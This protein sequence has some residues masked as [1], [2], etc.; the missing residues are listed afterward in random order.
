MRP[1]V[2]YLHDKFEYF[3]NLCYQGKLPHPEIKLNRRASSMG[4]TRATYNR[5]TRE[6]KVWIEISVKF[7]LPETEVVDTLLHEMIHYYIM[8]FDLKDS[9]QHG[10]LF[11]SEMRRLYADYG[12]KVS[13]KF[14][15]TNL[16]QEQLSPERRYF[17]LSKDLCGT[18]YITVVATSRIFDIWN[19]LDNYNLISTEWYVGIH[20]E[21]MKYPRS[22]GVKFYR[23][24]DEIVK[25]ILGSSR[26]LI[27]EG[28]I[29][30][31]A[32]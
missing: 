7:D 20:K 15:D 22:R 23:L 19:Q 6:K 5:Q 21:L 32:R 29:I 4:L 12:L 9:S 28:R 8:V 24:K 14:T 3:N 16:V 31:I 13:L 18:T 11:R 10:Q 1:T 17:C 30:R 2:E 25:D 27:R 26:R